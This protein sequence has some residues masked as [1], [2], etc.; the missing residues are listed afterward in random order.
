M[1]P[2]TWTRV[3]GSCLLVVALSGCLSAPPPTTYIQLSAGDGEPGQQPTP[4]ILVDSIRIPDYLLRNELLRRL[5]RNTINYDNRYRWAE[6]LDLG[7][8]RVVVQ[9]LGSA[10][11]SAGVSAFPAL[12]PGGAD[13]RL[14]ITL[15]HFEVQDNEAYLQADVRLRGSGQASAV[16]LLRHEARRN[17]GSDND[18]G[19]AAAALSEMLAEL[20]SEIANALRGA[21]VPTRESD[22]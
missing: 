19:A 15:R 9:R 18:G 5:D 6:P 22:Y 1:K 16:Q 11:N 7:I 13:W 8:Q 4:R 12:P 14:A 3:L 17:L 20:V 2:S 10:L 21:G